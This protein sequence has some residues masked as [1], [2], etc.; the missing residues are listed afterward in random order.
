MLLGVGTGGS[1]GVTALQFISKHY[2]GIHFQDDWKVTRKL[3]LNLGMRWEYQ[4]APVDRFNQQNYFDLN[5]TNPISSALG[6]T[7]KGDGGLQWRRRRR[8]RTLRSDQE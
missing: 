4:T 8:A 6:S 2:Y 5:A 3:T 7:V 1:T